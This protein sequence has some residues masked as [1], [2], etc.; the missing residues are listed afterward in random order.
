MDYDTV[1]TTTGGLPPEA[2]GTWTLKTIEGFEQEEDLSPFAGLPNFNDYIPSDDFTNWADQFYPIV[3]ES[4]EYNTV[5]ATDQ[6][7]SSYSNTDAQPAFESDVSPTKDPDVGFRVSY[8][9]P[10]PESN[11]NAPSGPKLPSTAKANQLRSVQ[12][13]LRRQSLKTL[14]RWSCIRTRQR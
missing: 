13:N 8:E 9:D 7:I 11:D 6:E 10:Q 12:Q 2:F 4:L 5:N 1:L 14:S 3:P